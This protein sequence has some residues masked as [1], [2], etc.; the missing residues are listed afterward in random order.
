MNKIKAVLAVP[1]FLALALFMAIFLLQSCDRIGGGRKLPLGKDYP[2]AMVELYGDTLL[3]IHPGSQINTKVNPS[4]AAL[5]LEDDGVLYIVQREASHFLYYKKEDGPRL[6]LELKPGELRVNGLLTSVV[7]DS[8]ARTASW[9]ESYRPESL[10]GLRTVTI[11]EEIPV[12]WFPRIFELAKINPSISFLPEN[13]SELP[14]RDLILMQ[15]LWK[16]TVPKLFFGTDEQVV[17]VDLRGSKAVYLE[18]ADSLPAQGYLDALAK[19]PSGG[20]LWL[21]GFSE[22]EIHDILLKT[23]P[24]ELAVEG[25]VIESPG[26]LA[27]WPG[28]KSLFISNPVRD[29]GILQPLE[30]LERLAVTADS[31]PANLNLIKN[32]YF[33]S[34]EADSATAF[35]VLAQNPDLQYLCLKAD[36]LQRFPDFS[37]FDKLKGLVLPAVASQDYSS[38]NTWKVPYIGAPVSDSV[39]QVIRQKAPDAMVYGQ[40][41]DFWG[42]CLGS[43]WLILLLPLFFLMVY[44]KNHWNVRKIT[45]V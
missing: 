12:A 6:D 21:D 27:A 32:L 19:M 23:R 34:L 44:V 20:R 30:A 38:V 13:F 25:S 37:K 18:K 24:G 42:A 22:K 4:G 40:G 8:S 3:A 33:L 43:G 39:L 29:F 26:T 16:A 7:L 1:V 36:T 11:G 15:G 41:K 35:G 17:S 10:S 14:E 2:F 31:A 9:L 45:E 5:P 28:L